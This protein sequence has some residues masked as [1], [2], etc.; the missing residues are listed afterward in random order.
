M[1]A[2]IY[3]GSILENGSIMQNLGKVQLRNEIVLIL[4]DRLNAL[5]QEGWEMINIIPHVGG[6]GGSTVSVNF[7]HIV[8]K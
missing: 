6:L 5:G 7:N 4:T 2:S 8:F 1:E 3:V